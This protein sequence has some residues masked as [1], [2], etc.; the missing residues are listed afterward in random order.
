MFFYEKVPFFFIIISFL[1]YD[2]LL[3]HD[4]VPVLMEK[5]LALIFNLKLIYNKYIFFL[6]SNTLHITY[7]V[8]YT[9]ILYYILY[10]YK[11]EENMVGHNST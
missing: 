6:L 2:D 4:S 10:T 7:T 3:F 11:L 8:H 1:E 9:I 5:T